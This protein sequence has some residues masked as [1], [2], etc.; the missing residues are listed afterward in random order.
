M[1]EIYNEECLDL[2]HPEIEAKEIK[3]R[4]DKDGKI[5]FTGAR[6]EVV[7]DAQSALFF[8]QQ[9]NLNRKTAGTRMNEASSRSHVRII[10][11]NPIHPCF[12]DL[13]H[14]LVFIF[15]LLSDIY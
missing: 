7:R 9:G 13:F 10:N 15:L 1:M 4:E 8:L 14:S 3:L 2:L 5:F 11:L 12:G 6:E